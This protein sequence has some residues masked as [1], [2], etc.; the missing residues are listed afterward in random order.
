M[1]AGELLLEREG[2]LAA[3]TGLV[4]GARAGRG[5]SLF[6]VGERRVWVRRPAWVRPL[7]WPVRWCGGVGVM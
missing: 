5:G 3:V 7:R 6:V 4:K 1:R 2:V